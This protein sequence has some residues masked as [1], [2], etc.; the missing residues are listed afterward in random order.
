MARMPNFKLP[1]VNRRCHPSYVSVQSTMDGEWDQID[2]TLL[3]WFEG[4]VPIASA[5]DRIH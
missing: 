1:V 2:D 4:R 3:Y 5:D